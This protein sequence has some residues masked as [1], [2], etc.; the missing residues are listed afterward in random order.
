M[1]LK[2]TIVVNEKITA[3]L[4]EQRSSTLS[5]AVW[6]VDDYTDGKPLGR[7][8]VFIEEITS[9]INGKE[10]V[11]KGLLNPGGYY[12]FVNLPAGDY[13]PRVES[14]FYFNNS[15]PVTD[16]QNPFVRI[17][18][19]KSKPNYPFPSHATLIRGNVVRSP[20][21]TPVQ[22]AKV[23]V[24]GREIENWTTSDG[25]FVLYFK[26]LTE[27]DIII[28]NGKKFVRGNNDKTIHLQASLGQETGI[29]DI[30]EGVE[31]G[32]TTSLTSPI[33]IS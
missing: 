12:L 16:P 31:E 17:I 32:K 4:V 10:G 28:E 8:K 1:S 3:F 29:I 20:G 6:L 5:M 13:D 33:M 9:I 14:E 18:T 27:T 7:I 25:E 26:A 23:E 2:E 19:L 22:G 11:L 21:N 30:S 15:T 24:T